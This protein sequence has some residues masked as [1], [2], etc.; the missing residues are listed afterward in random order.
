[1]PFVVKAIGNPETLENAL[2]M[3]G[4]IVSELRSVK[5]NVSIQKLERIDMNAYS[6]TVNFN[7]LTTVKAKQD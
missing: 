7:Y 6:G 4:G 2:N 1:M 3:V 5:I